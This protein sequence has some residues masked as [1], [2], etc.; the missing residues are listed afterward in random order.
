MMGEGSFYL[1]NGSPYHNAGT[2]AIDETTLADLKTMT[3]YPPV[4]YSGTSISTAMTLGI[5]AP[6]DSG[7]PG[8]DLGYHYDPLDYVFQGGR[9][10]HGF[11]HQQDDRRAR[12]GRMGRGPTRKAVQR[13]ISPCPVR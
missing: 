7:T 1:A 10:G 5:A 12:R 2:S 3:T 9:F 8:L 13:F 6:R 4:V 11:G